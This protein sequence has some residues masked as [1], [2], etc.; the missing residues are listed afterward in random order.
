MLQDIINLGQILLE[1]LRLIVH[2]LRHIVPDRVHDLLRHLLQLLFDRQCFEHDGTQF[3]VF[4]Q[5]FLFDD[6]FKGMNLL[7]SLIVESHVHTELSASLPFVPL[8]SK[9]VYLLDV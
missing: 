6:F 8:L 2:S 1:S 4:A 7:I 3:N 5:R 9:V